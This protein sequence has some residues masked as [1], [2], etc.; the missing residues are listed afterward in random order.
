MDRYGFGWDER[1]SGEEPDGL[2]L[3]H[4]SSA[5]PV[6]AHDPDP[7]VAKGISALVSA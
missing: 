5:S 1:G 2:Y 4:L 3:Q 7:Y 6:L